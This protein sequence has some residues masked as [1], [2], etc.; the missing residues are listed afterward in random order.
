MD[1]LQKHLKKDYVHMR[2]WTRLSGSSI[3]IAWASY[4]F[5]IPG[6]TRNKTFGSD[7]WHWLGSEKPPPTLMILVGFPSTRMFSTMAAVSSSQE[8][9]E[10]EME[11]EAI[12]PTNPGW[13]TQCT[14]NKEIKWRISFENIWACTPS[15]S[16]GDIWKSSHPLVRLLH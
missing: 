4:K 8:T 5:Q 16:G 2:L 6:M 7:A 1:I 9:P 14:H 10:E 15:F 12:V 13:I 3:I 11:D